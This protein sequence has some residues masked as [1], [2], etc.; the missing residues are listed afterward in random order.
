MSSL[1]SESARRSANYLAGPL[2][3]LFVSMSVQGCLWTKPSETRAME[4]RLG[5][6]EAGVG[7]H[8]EEL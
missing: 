4:D 6:L 3:L 5:E 1:F 8:S 2:A 7:A